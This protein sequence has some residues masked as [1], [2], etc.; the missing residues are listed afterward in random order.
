[1]HVLS[2][3]D[4]GNRRPRVSIDHIF[5]IEIP[6]YSDLLTKVAILFVFTPSPVR[7]TQSEIVTAINSEK[8]RVKELSGCERI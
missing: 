2:I 4:H 3:I 6:R 8:T 7:T 5:P 1:M